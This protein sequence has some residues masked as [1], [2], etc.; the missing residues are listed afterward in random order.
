M[1]LDEKK[2][3][4]FGCDNTGKDFQLEIDPEFAASPFGE[5]DDPSFSW[6]NEEQARVCV[7]GAVPS[8]E[9]DKGGERVKKEK[10]LYGSGPEAIRLRA[11]NKKSAEL[12][13]YQKV[14]TNLVGFIRKPRLQKLA[15]LFKE[16]YEISI[17]RDGRRGLWSLWAFFK[18]HFPNPLD[19]VT[20]IES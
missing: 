1:F 19:F 13:S 4:L 6:F 10:A 7:S 5:F 18:T 2:N 12:V 20:F 9:G 11:V 8:A 17:G 3:D 15:D 14:V 16:R